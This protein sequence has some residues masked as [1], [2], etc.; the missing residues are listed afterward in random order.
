MS[1]FD[2]SRVQCLFMSKQKSFTLTTSSH[3]A[4]VLGLITDH[5]QGIDPT[6]GNPTN[7][8][9]AHASVHE[10]ELTEKGFTSLKILNAVIED[11]SKKYKIAQT[12]PNST[13]GLIVCLL[14]DLD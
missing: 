14:K 8:R 4:T 5:N 13:T 6:N 3:S 10:D 9:N 1:I 2:A 7:A 11:G 12:M